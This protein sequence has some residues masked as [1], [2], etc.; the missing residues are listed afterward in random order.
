MK[1]YLDT[2]GCQM[3]VLD[4]ELVAAMLSAAGMTLTDDARDA[5]V[6]L[7]NTCSVRQHAEDKVH[8]RLGWA[9]R[10]KA[11]GARLIVGVLGC[12][13]QRLGEALLRRH[14]GLDI[15]CSPGQLARLPELIAAA[16]EA[17]QSAGRCAVALDPPRS[18]GDEDRPLDDALDAMR[19]TGA[20]HRPGQAYVRIM[21]GCDK[22][23]AYC[24]VP[25][26][27]GPERSRRPESIVEEVRR[28]VGAGVTQVTLLGQTV[29][30]YRW[31]AGATTVGLADLLGR[32][33]GIAG[34]RRL[35]FVTSYPAGFD[36]AILQAMRDLPSVCE[37][38]HVPAQSGSDRI[39]RAMNRRYTRA[40]YDALIDEAR[41]A[42]P[43]I[44]VAGDFIVGFP[45]E[46]EADHAASADLI[47]RSGYKNAYVFKYSPRPDTLAAR[48]GDDDVPDA[49]KR[50][51]N[52]ELLAVQN[53]VSL[54]GN[55]GWIGRTVEVLVEGPAPRPPRAGQ[56]H[57]LV[58]RTR[59][60]HIVA[61]DG[62]AEL[63]GRYVQ[64]Q[65][66]DATALAL[67]GRRMTGDD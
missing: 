20:T 52:N 63:A 42:V 21:R 37:Y 28:L 36:R 57:R 40:E 47:R 64:V 66:A 41:A 33:D 56:G 44:A 4:S 27:R 39:L 34:L 49:T 67:L 16:G 32:L 18:A 24:V 14:K 22:F 15:V 50:R 46:T 30:A 48:R 55:R 26:V 13:A 3:N 65:I 45:S 1:V 38:L 25:T 17:A 59:T 31:A 7:Y 10:R 51:R 12:M 8:S 19:D 6:L 35:R 61:F 2:M 43:G 60:D 5:D 54:A 62:P 9:C 29:N 11:D 23:C 58:G 53:D